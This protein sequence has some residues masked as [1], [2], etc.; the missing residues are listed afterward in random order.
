MP[1]PWYLKTKKKR[2]SRVREREI[3]R[4]WD[5]EW[6]MWDSGGCPPGPPVPDSVPWAEGGRG[7]GFCSGLSLP[8]AASH[9]VSTWW[10]RSMIPVFKDTYFLCN[11]VP[12]CKP[13][14]SSGAQPKKPRSV[15]MAEEKE[16]FGLIEKRC[17]DIECGT[18]QEIFKGNLTIDNLHLTCWFEI[19]VSV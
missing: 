14:A 17:V 16:I 4:G 3:N 5:M 1:I 9:N 18:S 12:K 13:T 15:P 8:E 7:G 2:E 6:E 19:S 11:M 10:C